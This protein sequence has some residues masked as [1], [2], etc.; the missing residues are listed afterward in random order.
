MIDKATARRLV[1]RFL[2]VGGNFFDTSPL[3][4]RGT[5]R[6]GSASS[7]RSTARAPSSRP[8][9][10]AAD[11]G[12]EQRRQPPE[13]HGAVARRVAPADG[14]AVRRPHPVHIWEY[15][16][17]IEEVMRSLDDI[18][19]AGKALYVGISDTP[20]WKVSQQHARA[21]PRDRP[22]SASPRYSAPNA[23]PN[24]TSSP[25]ATTSASAACRG[26]CSRR[27]CSAASTT[28]C[29]CRTGRRR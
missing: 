2:D 15:R 4:E 28:T 29:R 11:E 20:A 26:A 10:A 12:S 5:S 27:A 13:V 22:S 18:V 25:C 6:R 24:A 9:L 1:E 3:D 23:P 16:T 7:S 14:H 21:V 17:P 8:S 19:R